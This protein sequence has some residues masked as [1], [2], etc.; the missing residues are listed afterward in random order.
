MVC[1]NLLWSTAGVA[2]RHL[3]VIKGIELTFWRSAF[4]ALAMAVLLAYRGQWQCFNLRTY[5]AQPALRQSSLCW[6]VMF[7]CFM[8][9]MTYTSVG[10]VLIVMSIV[11]LLTAMLA[12]VLLGRTLAPH[13]WLAIVIMVMG[14]AVMFAQGAAV[15]DSRDFAGI[16]IAFGVPIAASYNWI[17]LQKNKLGSHTQKS[18]DSIRVDLMRVSLMRVDLIPAVFAGAVLSAALSAIFILA[19]TTFQGFAAP[20]DLAILAGLGFFQLALPCAMAVW[21]SRHLPAHEMA[22]LGVLEVI[23]G[24]LWAWLW[25]GEVLAFATILGG[26]MVLIALL[27]NEIGNKV[28]NKIGNEIAK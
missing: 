21:L 12:K 13:T 28:G 7:T 1:V 15:T 4:C 3:S 19:T 20:A 8:L 17:I 9:A 27:G 6:S 23:F 5:T 24:T 26:L 22:M 10:N 11:P 18:I 25:A 14:L 2:S 16:L